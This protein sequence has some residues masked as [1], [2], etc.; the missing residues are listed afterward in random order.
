MC[1]ISEKNPIEIIGASENN[2][3]CLNVTVPKG[4]LV[5]FAGISGSGKSSLVFDTIGVE[6]SR[7][8]QESYPLFL[9][10]RL[11][12]YERPKVEV[13]HN[14]TPAVVIDQRA[15][16]AAARST[17]GTAVDAAPL[18]RVLFSRVGVPG[19]GSA[20]AY[21]SNHPMGMCPDCTGL[22]E[23]LIIK[24]DSFFDPDRSIREGAILFSQFSTGW[25]KLLYLHNPYLDPD[26]KL[27]DFSDKEWDI[28]RN[29]T[30]EP[31]QIVVKSNKTGK[32]EAMG[33]YEGVLPR[34]SRLYV[35][36]ELTHYK[37]KLREEILAHVI[38]GPC[39]AC[40]GTGLN[41][42]ALASKIN[43]RNI[44]DYMSMPA[45][46]LLKALR[47]IHDPGGVSVVKQIAA[48]L[49]RM[50]EVGI[51]YLS[52]SRRTGTLSG[53]EIQRLKMVRN[54]GS[55][56]SD[57]TYIFDEPTA[58]LH[59]ADA[60]KIG[61]M[62]LKL[63]GKHNNVLVVEHS[64]QILALADHVIELGPLAGEKGGEIVYEGGL[65]G[66]RE[67]G[68]WTAR[69]MR[70][71]IVA[72][73]DPRPWTDGFE[74]RNASRHNL[75][76]VN[77]TVPKG[78]LTA[79]SGV[80]GSGK[81]TLA[82]VELVNC[83]PE[84]IVIDQKPIGTS[85]R[86][87]PA[88]YTGAMDEI[89]RLFAKE[90]GVT[91]AWFSFNSKGAC[92]V[93]K[94]AGQISY[95]LAFADP[96]V[97]PCEECGGRRYNPTALGYMYHGLNIEEVLALT[98]HQAMEFFEGG[99]VR[100]LLQSLADVGLGYLTL[101]QPTSRL[102]GG[103]IQRVKLASEMHR[104]GLLYILDEPGTGLHSKDTEVL[105]ALFRRLVERG[106]TVVMVEHRLELIAQADWVIDMGPDGGT[107][108]GQIVFQGTPMELLS[109]K[110]SK[111][112]RYMRQIIK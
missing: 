35:G 43:G 28:L 98:I 112:G 80:A 10:N 85:V 13:I 39:A 44:A 5:V 19:A 84:A 47:E 17:V 9:R 45:S 14:L 18:L 97:V 83:C 87:T 75:K 20:T 55:S 12:R 30:K 91:P 64:P 102:S 74:I 66:L 70:R 38:K 65:E 22:G 110:T 1:V 108:G 101:G 100:K 23:K 49:E 34:F 93:C 103:E 94:G 99:K 11:P 40:G 90:N 61:G 106:N 107:G 78:V 3:K 73:P 89:R 58:G 67:A 63:R 77:V 69:A 6:S 60:E 24:E 21:S 51:G 56:L 59:P 82:C 86:S 4:K 105:L 33:F 27:R 31:L 16:G 46:D 68:T 48:Y 71:R 54:L 42:G 7:E 50:V 111:T 52:L 32:E 25:Q 8:W 72:N 41:A 37:K 81:S 76:N 104:E 15:A 62:L 26:K 53:G 95:E 29:G 96:V 2:L 92:P 109:C 79:I 88:T 57:I 36:R